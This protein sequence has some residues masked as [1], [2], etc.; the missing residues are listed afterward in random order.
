MKHITSS[1]IVL[2]EECN[3]DCSFCYEKSKAKETMSQETVCKVI[4]FIFDN[5]KPSQD[6]FLFWFGGEPLLNFEVFRFGVK[7]A[8]EKAAKAGTRINHRISTNGTVWNDEIEQFFID[9][10]KVTL[11]VSWQ[12]LADIQDIDRGAADIVEANSARIAAKLF[13]P[14]NVQLQ[15]MP[16]NIYRLS[17]A[18]DHI[19]EVTKGKAAIILR[20]VP[21]ATGWDGDPAIIAEL[22]NQMYICCE[23][24]GPLIKRVSYCESGEIYHVNDCR[25]GREFCTFV[26]TGDIYLCHRFYFGQRNQSDKFKLGNLET[27]FLHNTHTEEYER[28][29]GEDMEGCKNCEAGVVCYKCFAC[30]YETTGDMMK[31]TVQNCTVN[32]AHASALGRYL[33][34]HKHQEVKPLPSLDLDLKNL[35]IDQMLPLL[36]FLTGQMQ[37]LTNRVT[38]LEEKRTVLNLSKPAK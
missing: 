13:N 18:V 3:M 8:N 20:P 16:K 28:Y 19:V 7:Y 34:E 33:S 23:K 22:E 25:A 2:T 38:T 10:P 1:S 4:D 5:Q 24:Y 21:E 27:G 32:R 30:N 9:N 36:L 15:I 35:C 17:E 14:F 31:P 6:L 29:Y 11:Q 37:S 12:G 26:P